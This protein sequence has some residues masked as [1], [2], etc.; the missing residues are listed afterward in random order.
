VDI[1]WL[2]PIFP[3]GEL[4]RKGTLG[5]YYAVKDYC[6]IN[7]DY[8][9]FDE[10]KNLVKKI[11]EIGMYVILDW[12]ANHTAWD[13]IWVY[14]HPN[15]Y[16]H[17][18]FGNILAPNADWHDVAHLNYQ[19]KDTR[20]AMTESLKF[21]ISE[22]DIDGYRCDMAGL[23]TNDFWVEVRPELEKLKN[24]FMLAE[25]EQVHIHDA[26]DMSYCWELHHLMNHIS[27]QHKNV[28]DLDHY[29]TYEIN[30]FDTSYYRMLFT[31]N[32]DENS[33]Q[34]SEYER[35]GDAALTWAVFTYCMP[36]MPLIYSGQESAVKKRL[37]FFEKDVINWDNYPLSEFYYK[38][39][40]LKKQNKA[41]WNGLHGGAFTKI[42]TTNNDNIYAFIRNKGENKLICIFNFSPYNQQ[43]K[44]ENGFINGSFTNYFSNETLTLATKQDITLHPWE[45]KV[46]ICN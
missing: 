19:S 15:R 2:M 11:H 13:H 39:N 10:F 12:V 34:G 24:V 45:Y 23:V 37:S 28:Y 4:N 43:F 16:S 1:L 31:S 29:R 6:A 5:S 30:T 46:F 32:H 21:W 33:W 36:G 18:E 38:L 35:M 9:T 42:F 41:L 40:T 8:G 17:D 26:F 20:F 22:C 27:R 25:W 44:M 7:P 14:N 3:I